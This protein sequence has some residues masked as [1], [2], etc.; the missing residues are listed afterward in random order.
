MFHLTQNCYLVTILTTEQSYCK[1]VT[2]LARLISH[3]ITVDITKLTASILAETKKT[4]KTPMASRKEFQQRTSSRRSHNR[5]RDTNRSSSTEI[6]KPGKGYTAKIKKCNKDIY[7]K[8]GS[9][10]AG[11]KKNFLENW[12]KITF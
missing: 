9:F 8:A 2:S 5:D 7:N 12:K 10:Q 1:P 3:Q 6:R 11:N 4:Q